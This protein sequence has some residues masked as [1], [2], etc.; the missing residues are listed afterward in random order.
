MMAYNG[1]T[2]DPTIGGHGYLKTHEFG[3]E[4][5][6]FTPTGGRCYGYI[7]RSARIDLRRLGGSAK[8]TSLQGVTVV[9]IARNPRDRK[10][11]IIGWYRNATIH[12]DYD[13]LSVRRSPR[14][15][16]GYQIETPM[17]SAHL[18]LPDQRLKSVPTAK[19]KGNMGQSPVWYGNP[20]F[21][22]EVVAYINGQSDEAT[23][24]KKGRSP[25]RPNDPE[26]RKLIE[27]AAISHAT[28]YYQSA[29]GGRRL[30][31]SVEGDWVGWDLTVTAGDELLKVEVK[32]L[33]GSEVCVEL[34]PN[35]YRTMLSIEH[36]NQYVIYIV[37]KAGTAAA[38]S[39][40]FYYHAETRKSGDHTWRTRNGRLLKIK[41][42]TGA[43]LSI[44]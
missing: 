22:S 19:Q 41:P 44:A 35:E 24:G 25:K 34:T 5:W 38:K 23:P 10:T 21:N 36:R 18:L 4:A 39:H 15:T 27:L 7:P 37:T 9:W 3:H 28:K 17:I 42:I 26:A 32:G 29:E 14:I 31:E 13:I 33:S 6:N 11:K 1:P 2:N 20:R 40:V 12:K 43:R 8:D 30:V 16:V